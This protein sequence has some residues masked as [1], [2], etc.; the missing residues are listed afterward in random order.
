LCHH[1]P[2]LTACNDGKWGINCTNDCGS[3]LSSPCNHVNGSCE[4]GCSS[5]YKSTFKCDIGNV[6]IKLNVIAVLC[7]ILYIYIW[8]NLKIISAKIIRLLQSLYVKDL[9]TTIQNTQNSSYISLIKICVSS[10]YTL[11]FYH[12]CE[13]YDR[14]G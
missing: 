12:S 14:K 2:L 10:L 7:N 5:G 13:I 9:T 3:C 1:S 8:Y 4:G 11:L 6:K